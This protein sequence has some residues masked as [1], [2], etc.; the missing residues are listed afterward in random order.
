MCVICDESGED[1]KC[2]ANTFQSNGLEISQNFLRIVS[3]FRGLEALPVNVVHQASKLPRPSGKLHK[4]C[5]LKFAPSKLLKA[6][7]QRG[8]N[9]RSQQ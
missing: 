5:H 8:K 3:E 6:R 2:P 4:S 9:V 7:E 1:L